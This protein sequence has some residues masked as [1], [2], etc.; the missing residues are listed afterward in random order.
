[1]S[2]YL[3]SQIRSCLCVPGKL[4]PAANKLTDGQLFEVFNRLRKGQNPNQVGR[5]AQRAWGFMKDRTEH[6]CGQAVRLLQKRISH[7]I[8]EAPQE[9]NPPTTGPFSVAVNPRGIA[10]HQRLYDELLE[11]TL[12]LLAE[13]RTTGI[14]YKDLAKDALAVSSLSKSLLKL[15]EF[16]LTNLDPL[17][18]HKRHMQRTEQK[19]MLDHLISEI[20][21]KSDPEQSQVLNAMDRFMELAEENAITLEEAE[22]GKWEH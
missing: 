15:K 10:G 17:E 19:R 5:Y 20:Q 18:I 6:T 3:I 7:L 13:E 1:M 22:N 11:R 9:E 14:P 16:E 21:K 4:E 8:L 12:R 2:K